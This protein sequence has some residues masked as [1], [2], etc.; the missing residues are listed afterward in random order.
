MADIALILMIAAKLGFA[1]VMVMKHVSKV[2]AALIEKNSDFTKIAMERS[3]KADK[4]QGIISAELAELKSELADLRKA[5]SFKE[6]PDLK[7][8]KN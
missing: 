8:K 7:S 1:S 5:A 2:I 6:F 3:I 4:H